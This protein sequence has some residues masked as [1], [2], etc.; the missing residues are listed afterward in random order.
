MSD[1]L[2]RVKVLVSAGEV[3]VSRHGLQELAADDIL[4]GDVVAGVIGA[5]AVENY[6][7]FHKGPSI[8]A[9]QRDSAG[10]PIHV[11]WGVARG[12]TRP[13]V[14]VTAYRPDPLRWNDDFEARR[15]R[16]KRK[17][18]ELIHEGKYA[19]E[20]AIELIYSDESWSPTMSL[21]DAQRLEAVRLSLQ[22]GDVTEAAKHGRVFELT[23]VAAK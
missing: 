1:T 14:L 19:V 9:L 15:M 22:R 12:T 6:P 5:E 13:A 8:L 10:R 7:D 16:T 21:E 18:K 20:V 17:A 3:E 4:L 23:P 11:L 2:E